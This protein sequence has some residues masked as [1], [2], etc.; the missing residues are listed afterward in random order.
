MG[1]DKYGYRFFWTPSIE[2]NRKNGDYYQGKPLNGK[3]YIEIPFPNYIDFEPSFNDATNEG[4]IPYRNGKKPVDFLQ[5]LL[6]LQKITSNKQ[7]IVLDYFAGSAST[8]HALVN[9]NRKDKGNRKYILVQVDHIFEEVTK[10]R[11][12]KVIYSE[13]WNNGKPVSRKGSSHCFKYMRLEQYED[14]LNNLTVTN[15]VFQNEGDYYYVFL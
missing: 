8:G 3:D 15:S 6:T 1:D 10:P 13:D 5:H 2:S 11:M 9:L 14:T 4:G 7:S 12:E